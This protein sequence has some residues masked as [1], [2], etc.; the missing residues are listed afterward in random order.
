MS[1][2][3]IAAA[4]QAALQQ[5]ETL[6][7]LASALAPPVEARLT[8]ARRIR[9]TQGA[10]AAAR[11]S[12]SAQRADAVAL[13]I[14]SLREQ[15]AALLATVRELTQ[16]LA[17]GQVPAQSQSSRGHGATTGVQAAVQV[18]TESQKKKIKQAKKTDAWVASQHQGNESW[19]DRVRWLTALWPT[20]AAAA[21]APGKG[22]KRAKPG[23]GQRGAAS[24][25][26]TNRVKAV[27]AVCQ[28]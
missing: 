26:T 28:F 24:P 14:A 25:A 9:L 6:A 23:T 18:A 3:P 17:K 1:T 11:P 21:N 16:Q 22:A 7:A 27:Q 10:E 19:A 4:L 12:P 20:P 13:E 8:A 2:C 5:P 15:V